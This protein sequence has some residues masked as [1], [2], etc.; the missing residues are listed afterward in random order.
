[1]NKRYPAFLIFFVLLFVALSPAQ[2][3]PKTEQKSPRQAGKETAAQVEKKTPAAAAAKPWK[4]IPIPP[5]PKFSPA[6]PKRIQ[7]ANGMV[8]FLQED[9]ELPLIDAVALIRGGARLEP[10]SKVGLVD[11]YGDVWRTGGTKT[12]TGDQLDDFL[13]ARAAKVETNGNID[14]TTISLNC[15]KQDFDDVFAAFLDVLNNPEFRE[16][17]IDIAKKQMNTLISRR[18]DDIGQV[19]RRETAFL[20]YGKNNPYARIAEY[21]T[22]AAVTREDLLAWHQ[23]YVHPNN[24]IFGIVGDFDSTAMEARLRKAFDSWQKGPQAEP[25]HITPDPAKP[26]LYFAQKDDVNQS[27]IRMVTLGIEKNNP[28]YFAVVVL[29]EVFG[30]GSFSSRLMKNIRTTQGLA[31]SVSG[32]IGSG[33]DHPGLFRIAMG[34]KIENTS[35][36]IKSLN[37]QIEGIIKSP[38]TEDELKLA[39][40]SIL[41]SFI[42]NFD[43]PD[44]VLRE[45]MAYEYY[46]YPADFLEQF[47]AGIEKVTTADVTRV[48][49]KY[50]HPGQFATLVVGTAEAGKQLET[51]GPVAKL[52]INIPVPGQSEA[53]AKAAS[54]NLEGKALIAKVV[55]SVGGAEKIAAVKSVKTNSIRTMSTPQGDMEMKGA[56][57]IVLP[58]KVHQSLSTQMGEVTVVVTPAAAFMNMGG[59][60]Q[61]MPSSQKPEA[62]NSIKRNI[63]SVAQ[64]ADDP[65]YSFAVTGNQKIGNVDARVLDINADGQPLKW[66]VDPQTG[67]VLRAVYPTVGPQGP[68]EVNTDYS[69]WKTTDGLTIPMAQTSTRN[70]QPFLSEKTES[71]QINPQIDPKLFDKP[72][73]APAS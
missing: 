62:I 24:M 58:D 22:V 54:S 63:I 3:A 50:V 70:G 51:L 1:M 7:F 18:N 10:A 49:H 41:N 48:A 67:H 25:P 2:T 43:S 66:F 37:D 60:V 21:S 71:I 27:A 45:R 40:D 29:N 16:E 65:K 26:G 8:I 28:D 31:Y 52:D 57:T 59:Q 73:G 6:Q 5:L 64:H 35:K 47:R 61:D 4:Q 46:G 9:H 23:R 36:A 11:I 56:T 20:G 12:R 38:A 42:F 17:K 68:A 13:E 39:K 53:S 32:G 34:T 15:L 14:S 55:E 30:G 33:Y 19:A 69:D 72:A 44:K